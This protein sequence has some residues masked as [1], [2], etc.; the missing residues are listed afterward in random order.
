MAVAASEVEL[1]KKAME[2]V[3]G[4]GR[5]VAV[6]VTG[7]LTYTEFWFAEEVSVTGTPLMATVTVPLI[8]E[9]CV[10]SPG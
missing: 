8:A 10:E 7:W 9:V 4:E 2:P 5:L 3:A 1:S 6:R